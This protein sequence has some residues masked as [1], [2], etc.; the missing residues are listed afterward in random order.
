MIRILGWYCS[1]DWWYDRMYRMGAIEV[2]CG[3]EINEDQAVV[4][5]EAGGDIAIHYVE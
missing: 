4:V 5:R 3:S 1:V 2:L